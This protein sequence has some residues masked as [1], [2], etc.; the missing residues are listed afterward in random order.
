MST[1]RRVLFA[2]WIAIVG[3]RLR[4]FW[5]WNANSEDNECS[6]CHAERWHW[7][8]SF[9]DFLSDDTIFD[10]KSHCWLLFEAQ[11]SYIRITFFSNNI[12]YENMRSHFYHCGTL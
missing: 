2:V 10:H 6:W 1:G 11:L 9:D 3:W 4:E 12:T 8:L 7:V 5:Q